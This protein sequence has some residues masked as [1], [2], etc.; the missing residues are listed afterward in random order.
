MS[1]QSSPRAQ[2]HRPVPTP[3]TVRQ[4]VNPAAAVPWKK[5]RRMVARA[6]DSVPINLST[7]SC[8]KISSA[9]PGRGGQ[10]ANQSWVG[11]ACTHMRR[12]IFLPNVTTASQAQRKAQLSQGALSRDG[13]WVGRRVTWHGQGRATQGER[14]G[15]GGEQLR[16]TD[17]A[18]HCTHSKGPGTSARPTRP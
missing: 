13:G 10:G 16:Q 18:P 2:H 3:H 6:R 17:C 9:N 11:E 5:N 1:T 8:C 15:G 12:S 14:T 4:Y 7:A